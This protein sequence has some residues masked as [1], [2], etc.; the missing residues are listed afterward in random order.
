MNRESAHFKLVLAQSKRVP[1]DV[2]VED[3][4]HALIELLDNAPDLT[5]QQR[6]VIV[7]AAAVLAREGFQ[8]FQTGLG[9]SRFLSA[10]RTED[11]E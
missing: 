11:D 4:A 6:A 3:A 9:I 10:L 7:G 2:T 5:D 1:A 8:K